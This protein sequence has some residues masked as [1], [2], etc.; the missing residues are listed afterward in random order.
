[1]DFR[2]GRFIGQ[3]GN[4]ALIIDLDYETGHKSWGCHEVDTIDKLK[5]YR[6]I[7]MPNSSELLLEADYED[8]DDSFADGPREIARQQY[9]NSHQYSLK[10]R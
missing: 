6:F 1:M 4:G 3:P 7:G 9:Q 10:M 5:N 2:F 8:K